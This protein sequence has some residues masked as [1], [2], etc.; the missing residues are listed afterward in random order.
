MNNFFLAS[1]LREIMPRNAFEFWIAGKFQHL[2][3]KY[4][5][6]KLPAW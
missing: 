5:I 1:S 3:K 6:T 4:K 2:H